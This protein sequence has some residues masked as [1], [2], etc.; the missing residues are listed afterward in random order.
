M[1]LTDLCLIKVK[2]STKP[3]VCYSEVKTRSL[4]CDKKLAIQGHDSLVKDDALSNPEILRFISTWFYETGMLEEGKFLSKIRLGIQEYD[5][6]HD[7]FLVHDKANWDNEILENLNNY[8]LDS[9]LRDFSVKV[10][11]ITD[12]RNLIDAVYE[13]AWIAAKGIV[14]G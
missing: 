8:D 6:R 11:L 7:L 13:R 12:L 4:G 9:R 2:D 3:I 5:K 14:D 1:R 10:V